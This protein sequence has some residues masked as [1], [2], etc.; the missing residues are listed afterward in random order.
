MEKKTLHESIIKICRNLHFRQ[1]FVKDY[2]TCPQ[3]SLYRWIL[4]LEQE[5]PWMAGFLGTAGHEVIFQMHEQKKFDY[6]YI[7]MVSAFQD[8]FDQALDDSDELPRIGGNYDSI[9]EQFADVSMEY[10]NMLR[11][12]QS[13]KQHSQFM[14][15]IHEQKFTME[16]EGLIFT[17]MIDQAGY[18][19]DGTFVLRD[20]KFR[21][22]AFRPSRVEFDLDIQMTTYAAGLKY[23]NPSCEECSPRHNPDGELV[24]NGPCDS[25]ASKIGTP[26]WPRKYAERCEMIWMRDYE[27]RKKDQHSKMI[28][29]PNKGKVI[30]PK[31][32]REVIQDVIN[33]KWEKGYKKGDF[34]GPGIIKTARSPS[35]IDVFMSD[36]IRI[37]ELIRNGE[38]YRN[39]GK[40]CN[41][42][43]QYR[44]QCVRGAELEVQELDMGKAERYGTIDPFGED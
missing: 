43:C 38:F 22:E 8:A 7:D 27:R 41:F 34:K 9:E 28:K 20:I 1:S 19:E 31:T 3:M 35:M 17:G 32:G 10:I 25:C 39:P 36:I 42:W 23:G 30:N 26:A 18:Y 24:Y 12:Y 37:V 11:G 40:Q 5:A 14:S 29:D 15:T 2:L 44:E 16:I 4:Q 6:S 21:Q 33:P 13:D